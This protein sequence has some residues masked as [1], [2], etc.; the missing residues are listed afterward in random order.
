MDELARKLVIARADGIAHQDFLTKLL[1][2]DPLII[3][4][5]RTVG[6]DPDAA[7]DVFAILAGRE[8]RLPTVVASQ[9]GLDYWAGVLPDRVAANSVVKFRRNGMPGRK[10]EQARR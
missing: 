6:I 3:D 9:S 8:H 1:E 4:D 7:S 10:I 5:F 2:M